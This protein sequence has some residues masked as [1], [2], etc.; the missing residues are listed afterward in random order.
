[1]P[2]VTVQTVGVTTRVCSI[3]R[4][5]RLPKEWQK[6]L[7]TAT[8]QRFVQW[9]DEESVH[10]GK[11]CVVTMVLLDLL[12]RKMV[13]S[14]EER[15][16]SSHVED[17]GTEEDMRPFSVL[18]AIGAGLS[19]CRTINNAG[20]EH[21]LQGVQEVIADVFA[22]GSAP[23]NGQTAAY[24]RNHMA[25]NVMVLYAR[26]AIW[27]HVDKCLKAVFHDSKAGERDCV[28]RHIQA[29]T[30]LKEGIVT[31]MMDWLE[32]K[33][34]VVT[35]LKELHT[36]QPK[37]KGKEEEGEGGVAPPE[38]RQRVADKDQKSLP[39]STVGNEG[40][41]EDDDS[42]ASS[43]DATRM[44]LLSSIVRHRLLM[45]MEQEATHP[46]Y[47]SPPSIPLLMKRWKRFTFVPVMKASRTF[48]SIDKLTVRS[49]LKT[50]AEEC[51]LEITRATQD[52]SRAKKAKME[53]RRLQKK[54]EDMKRAQ[55]AERRTAR[56][57]WVAERLAQ[58]KASKKRP[59]E[60]GRKNKKQWE[61]D[62]DAAH[63]PI[64]LNRRERAEGVDAWQGGDDFDMMCSTG[65]A[66]ASQWQAFLASVEARHVLRLR[67]REKRDGWKCMA[68]LKTNGIEVHV[69]FKVRRQKEIEWPVGKGKPPS[70]EGCPGDFPSSDSFTFPLREHG[71]WRAEKLTQEDFEAAGVEVLH[72]V[73]PGVK[74]I[75]T[76]S[77]C[78]VEEWKRS[79][80][81]FMTPDNMSCKGWTRGQYHNHRGSTLHRYRGKRSERQ[82]EGEELP[83]GGKIQRGWVPQAVR[84]V[85]AK[86]PTMKV[87]TYEEACDAAK[88]RLRLMLS[89]E[90]WRFHSCRKVAR[91]RF[92]RFQLGQ[93]ALDDMVN[94][95]APPSSRSAVVFGNFFGRRALKG[96]AGVAPVK[97]LRRHLAVTRRLLIL[98]EFGTTK[99]C[100]FCDHELTH[101][102]EKRMI[103]DRKVEKLLE[104]EM[105]KRGGGM[106][107]EKEA[108]KDKVRNVQRVIN[109]VS[110]CPEHGRMPRDPSASHNMSQCFFSL[111]YKGERPLRLQRPSKPSS[112]GFV[113]GESHG[114]T[115]STITNNRIDQ[116]DMCSLLK[117]A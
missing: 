62:Y 30:P 89:G 2:K 79:E 111:L 58:Q 59:R 4:R 21:H 34:K 27:N 74:N 38:K 102:K 7:R 117:L 75:F 88:E 73:D 22:K 80:G 15:T 97:K 9:C 76:S 114:T 69:P 115:T 41:Q 33:V 56:S 44:V 113:D 12:L 104:R 108:F 26:D 82:K 43:S 94:T 19:F 17:E 93:K 101:P 29:G 70:K 52:E 110:I 35:E 23:I 24:L 98:D 103:R 28:L 36:F 63:P 95:I 51:G 105:E 96:E 85:R 60:E 14:E 66:S 83:A 78:T 46:S 8:T 112:H 92:H 42:L 48:V 109:G 64:P 40:E 72:F 55:E 99:M 3:N 11:A 53:E 65:R 37:K 81:R 54:E 50:C 84:E 77:S 57:A 61:E 116:H 32:T 71:A 20:S 86:L 100:S 45:A 39:P 1:M 25:G 106:T 18:D 87:F 31:L 10:A 67:K 6:L 47:P 13:A 68:T 107:E 5:V 16:T 91:N 49:F 90:Y